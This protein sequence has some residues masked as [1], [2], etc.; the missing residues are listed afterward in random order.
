[1]VDILI[2]VGF[3]LGASFIIDFA[4]RM[5][6][7]GSASRTTL[8]YVIIGGLGLLFGFLS[9]MF[10]SYSMNRTELARIF[11]ILLTPAAVGG[12]GALLG[13]IISWRRSPL[14]L[15]TLQGGALF[16]A[17]FAVIRYLL[18]THVI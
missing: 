17:S 9:T 14:R 2:E 6:W 7:R 11:T 12:I 1:V 8:G 4:A 5:F 13:W 3:A 18:T 15:D 16:G 10:W